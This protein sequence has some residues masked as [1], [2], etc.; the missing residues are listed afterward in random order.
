[1]RKV[2]SLSNV[3]MPKNACSISVKIFEPSDLPLKCVE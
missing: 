3:L 2:A 1:M